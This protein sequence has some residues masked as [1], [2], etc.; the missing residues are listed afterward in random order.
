MANCCLYPGVVGQDDAPAYQAAK[1][2]LVL[3][4]RNAAVTYA[5]HGIRVNSLSPSVATTGAVDLTD[6]RSASFLGRVPLA[7]AATPEEVAAAAV[8]LASD[9]A[10]QVTAANRPVDGGYLA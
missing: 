9:D 7:R 4:T 10:S 8:F 3:L 5:K 2:G 6:E 1:A